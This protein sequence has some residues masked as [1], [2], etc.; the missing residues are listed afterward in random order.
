MLLYGFREEGGRLEAVVGALD[1]LALPHRLLGEEDLERTLAQLAET[2]TSPVGEPQGE[3]RGELLLMKG[4]GGERIDA[5]LAALLEVGP[6][7]ARKAVYTPT[8][9][10]WT[11]GA[12]FE[13]LTRESRMMAAY[14][15]LRRGVA[16]AKGIRV[17]TGGS[18]AHAHLAER[19][20]EAKALLTALEEGE[21]EPVEAGINHRAAQLEE[22]LAAV[23]EAEQKEMEL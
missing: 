3:P 19:L 7:I 12:L 1:A 14:Q 16:R 22:A 13:E 18:P 17:P 5:L 8:N 21:T 9:S 4:L 2:Q 11:L 23:E 10:R 20:G 6:P 15:R